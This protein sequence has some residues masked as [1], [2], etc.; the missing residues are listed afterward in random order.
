MWYVIMAPSLC[1]WK[2]EDLVPSA[3]QGRLAAGAVLVVTGVDRGWGWARIGADQGRMG[4][5][6][7]GM[8]GC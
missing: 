2:P 6:L 7:S 4:V 5:D 1:L 8:G 3:S